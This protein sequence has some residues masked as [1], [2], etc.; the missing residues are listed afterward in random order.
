MKG[1]AIEEEFLFCKSLETTTIARDV[2]NKMKSFFDTSEIPLQVIGSICTDG[3][4]ILLFHTEVRW[5]S[6]GRVLTRFFNLRMEIEQ[7]LRKQ[8]C[9]LVCAFK[10]PY[11]DS[12]LAY[13][14]DI[15]QP[16][17]DFNLSIQGNGMNI[18]TSY[19]LSERNYF[20][21]VHEFRI[22]ILLI[23]LHLTK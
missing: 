11:F 2:F 1:N 19:E 23:S 16:L 15:F 22:K 5:L 14:A 9:D 8:K 12:M 7:F 20:C 18:V 3:A 21:G 13:L 6:R 17:N 4:S 10:V